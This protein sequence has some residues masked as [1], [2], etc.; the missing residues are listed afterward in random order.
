M[1]RAAQ[2]M[3]ARRSLPMRMGRSGW[4]C[5]DRAGDG[6]EKSRVRERASEQYKQLKQVMHEC[7]RPPSQPGG[8][9]TWRVFDASSTYIGQLRVLRNHLIHWATHGVQPARPDQLS[10]H[11]LC[12][13]WVRAEGYLRHLRRPRVVQVAG[14]ARKNRTHRQE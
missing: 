7:L 6:R 2:L 3:L 4:L 13:A 5:T 11:G 9:T 12:G 1:E 8:S 14:A 10:L